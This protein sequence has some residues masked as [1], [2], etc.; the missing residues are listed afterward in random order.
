MYRY[1]PH[2]FP[3]DKSDPAVESYGPRHAAYMTAIPAP[4]DRPLMAQGSVLTVPRRWRAHPNAADESERTTQMMVRV[5]K[6]ERPLDSSTA[7]RTST[8]SFVVSLDDTIE[9]LQQALAPMMAPHATV[10][11]LLADTSPT[12]LRRLFGRKQLMRINDTSKVRSLLSRGPIHVQYE[13]AAD[14]QVRPTGEMVV[15]A[16]PHGARTSSVAPVTA[17]SLVLNS[18]LSLSS[19]TPGLFRKHFLYGLVA[20]LFV[21]AWAMQISATMGKAT[22]RGLSPDLVGAITSPVGGVGT[23]ARVKAESPEESLE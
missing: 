19:G 7:T 11:A 9:T 20:V 21:A 8:S 23:Q 14:V 10:S 13:P 15:S 5:T 3:V 16:A 18:H 4:A 1:P 17:P 22:Q 12:L 2:F 6:H